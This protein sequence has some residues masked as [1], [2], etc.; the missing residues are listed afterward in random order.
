[1]TVGEIWA[2][3]NVDGRALLVKPR[4]WDAWDGRSKEPLPVAFPELRRRSAVWIVQH[5]GRFLLCRDT[6]YPLAYPVIGRMDAGEIVTA[7]ELPVLLRTVA[8]RED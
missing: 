6:E 7:A 2:R 8:T 4:E 3:F 5:Q 1:M